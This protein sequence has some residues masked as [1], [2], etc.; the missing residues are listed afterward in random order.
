[1]SGS[2]L[3]GENGSKGRRARSHLAKATSVPRG[4]LAA[5]GE[6]Q[7]K[8]CPWPSVHTDEH[9]EELHGKVSTSE[10]TNAKYF[11]VK[12]GSPCE[13]NKAK[14]NDS[15]HEFFMEGE[16]SR[17]E[18]KGGESW[19]SARDRSSREPEKIDHRKSAVW[20]D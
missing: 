19:P 3:H 17:R 6:R 16:K 9:F 11:A 2:S 14:K 18:D 7:K 1:M 15:S 10:S 8:K 5:V 20:Q 12:R 4:R 13:G